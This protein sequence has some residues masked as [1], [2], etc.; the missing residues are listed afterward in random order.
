[1][2]G[3]CFV[4]GR[5]GRIRTAHG[6]EGLGVS[7]FGSFASCFVSHHDYVETPTI[8]EMTSSKVR[9][10]IHERQ[11][12]IAQTEPNSLLSKTHP[13]SPH[14]VGSVRGAARQEVEEARDIFT[15]ICTLLLAISKSPHATQRMC[16]TAARYTDHLH[17]QSSCVRS[18]WQT[19]FHFQENMAHAAATRVVRSCVQ[20]SP[21]APKLLMLVQFSG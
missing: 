2:C 8:A 10:Q 20:N 6:R 16:V 14:R 9:C 12:V 21:S 7:P 4:S 1:M 13:E 15:F 5:C 18:G 11:H 17:T 3:G 19:I